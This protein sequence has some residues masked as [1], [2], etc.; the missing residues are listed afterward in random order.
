ML[1]GSRSFT[2]SQVLHVGKYLE[3]STTRPRKYFR[4]FESHVFRQSLIV[5]ITRTI[6]NQGTHP[7]GGAHAKFTNY[8]FDVKEFLRV[9]S[10]A[11]DYV[12]NHNDFK[13]FLSKRAQRKR[14]EA[15]NQTST[16]DV[17]EE[18]DPK[19]KKAN[20]LKP[21]IQSKDEL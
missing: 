8:S 7:D 6:K 16:S 13:K 20:E 18:K 15:K 19:A 4:Q 14:T 9:V 21:V 17:N 12:K 10:L 5:L 1:Q 11:T 3:I 2:R